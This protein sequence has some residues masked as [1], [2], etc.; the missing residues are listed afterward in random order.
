MN[1]SS[2]DKNIFLRRFEACRCRRDMQMTESEMPDFH[3]SPYMLY[4][5]SHERIPALQPRIAESFTACVAQKLMAFFLC[6]ECLYAKK[7]AQN[8]D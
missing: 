8:H 7:F 2:H 5:L 1:I 6:I 4:A 3:Q